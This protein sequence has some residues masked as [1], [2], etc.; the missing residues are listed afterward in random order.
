VDGEEKVAE[1]PNV[2]IVA[3]PRERFSLW[4]RSLE[5][6]FDYTDVPFELVCVDARS[7][8]PTRR[9]LERMARERGF[10]LVRTDKYLTPNQARNVGL[11]RVRTPYVC[12]V[13]NDL[14]VT[15]GWLGHLVRCAEETGAWAVGPLYLEGKPE[16]RII[17]VAGGEI[18]MG[19][20][21]AGNRSFSTTHRFQGVRMDDVPEPLQRAQCGFVEFH[22]LLARTDVFDKIG[23][24]DEELMS[25]REHLDFCLEVREAGGEVWFEPSSIVTYV[26][27][28]PVAPRDVP[29]FWL[30]W[31]E[32]WSQRSLE[33]FCRKWGLE[34]GYADRLHVMRARRQVV[35]EPMRSVTRKLLGERGDR[36]L[37]RI[38]MRAERELNKLLVRGAPRPT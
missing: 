6:L 18:E 32:S 8:G 2:T 12:F 30:R 15:P 28:P 22:C 34:P 16:D 17:H 11:E 13:D 21:E 35:F 4:E 36:F 19:D 37:G 27:P 25:T 20:G 24:L 31:S 7:P 38:L 26:T 10:Q 9:G 33:H 1:S 3:V 23:P 29:Y 14:F 5:T